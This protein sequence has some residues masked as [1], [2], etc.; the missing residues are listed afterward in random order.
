MSAT[1]LRAD[2]QVPPCSSAILSASVGTA[3]VTA[4]GSIQ[5]DPPAQLLL[6]P[7]RQIPGKPSLLELWA[8]FLEAN[9]DAPDYFVRLACTWRSRGHS[10]LSMRDLFGFARVS[11]AL[12]T[13]S[14]PFSLNNSF[15][16]PMAREVIRRDPS[17]ASVFRFR[18]SVTD[19]L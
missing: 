12:A 13:D 16:A 9:P 17:L 15:T 19:A 5:P 18:E 14:T 7:V 2:E 3:A 4:G 10:Y 8:A 1:G 11:H 6:F